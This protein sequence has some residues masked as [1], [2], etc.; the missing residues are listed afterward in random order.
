VEGF[1]GKDARKN[2]IIKGLKSSKADVI[3]LQEV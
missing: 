3:C 1:V 2:R